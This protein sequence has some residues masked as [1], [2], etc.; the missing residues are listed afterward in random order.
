MKHNAIYCKA[1]Q[2]F[3]KRL[4]G[5]PGEYLDMLEESAKAYDE[6][7][8]SSYKKSLSVQP[9]AIVHSLVRNSLSE[10]ARIL[11]EEGFDT[12]E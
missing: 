2:L 6:N 10:A 3:I 9:L 4:N 7:G 12:P 5:I 11:K 1:R 8:D